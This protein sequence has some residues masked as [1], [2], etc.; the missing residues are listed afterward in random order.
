[1]SW[2]AVQPQPD[3]SAGQDRAERRDRGEAVRLHLLATEAAAHPQA[4]HGDVMALESEHVR[5]DLLGLGRVLGAALHEHLA[6]LVH[7]RDRGVGLEVEVF[8]P[9]HLGDAA[10]DVGRTGQ[11]L[12]DVAAGDDGLA[13][14]E[15]LGGDRLGQRHDRGQ[16]FVVDL[17]GRGSQ[18]CRLEGV[19]EH[20]ADGVPHEHHD[21]GEERLV[22]L[23]PGVV[24]AGHVVGGQD[25]H[26]ARH[27][28]R[29]VGAKTDHPGVG[30]RRADR[31][32][33][34]HVVR[35]VHQV[36]GVERVPGD[37]QGRALVGQCL[38][39]AHRSASAH[40]LRSA[41]A[42]IAAR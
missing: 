36:V 6:A 3:R 2:V 35:A 17:D 23:H 8:L 5:H 29:G 30:V 40:T 27:R 38:A 39:D 37:V 26:H 18:A 34:Q 15:A 32:G 31:V 42:S 21:L 16:R 19:G 25:P 24:G 10:E 14:L 12:L 41:L 28:Q 13:A 20:P 33:V 22:V 4:L 9:G 1:M 11:P 7:E